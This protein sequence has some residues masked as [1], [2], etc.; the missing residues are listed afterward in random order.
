MGKRIISTIPQ[1]L[2]YTSISPEGKF[3]LK[4]TVLNYFGF[5][6]VQILYLDTKNELLLTTNKLGEQLSVMPTNWLIIPVTA[7]KKLQL[8]SRTNICFLQRQNG[9][10]I[11]RFEIAVL[12]RKRPRIV[13]LESTYFVTRQIETFSELQFAPRL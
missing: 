13:D 10:A 1:V 3:K 5:N 7:Q 11:K 2:G 8:K 9:V 4:K 6:D 12:Q